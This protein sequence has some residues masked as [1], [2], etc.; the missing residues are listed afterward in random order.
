MVRPR[1][2][3][4]EN[5]K[6]C[7]SSPGKGKIGKDFQ[8]VLTEFVRVVCK[9][10]PD[11]PMSDK[12]KWQQSGVLY[13][14][15]DDGTPFSIAWRLHDAKYFNLAQRRSRMCVLCD[16]GGRED[17][18]ILMDLQC[19]RGSEEDLEPEA[20]AGSGTVV[21]EASEISTLRKGLRWDT[22]P[23]ETERKKV[24]GGVAYRAG[25]TIGF[26]GY[27]S[28]KAGMPCIEEAVPP[29]VKSAPSNVLTA[30]FSYG[31]SASARSIAWEEEMSPTL[32]G[33]EGGNNKPCILSYQET[34]GTLSPGAHPGSYNGQDAYNDL[35]VTGVF[36]ASSFGNYKCGVTSLRAQ[37]GDNGGGSENIV[38][39]KSYVRRLTPDECASLQGF[40]RNWCNIG[41]WVDS[42]GKTHKDADT[43]KYK[44]YGN[45]IAVG[46]ANGQN[47]F[48]CWLARRICAQYE[49]QVTMAS[50]F[51]GIGGFPLAFSACGAIPVW[52]SEIEE[53]PIAVT[54]RRFPE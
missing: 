16:Y 34:T 22:E 6:G 21:G 26:N 8:A 28:A 1:W 48:W 42:K 3:V 11:V 44:A 12:G 38:V 18:A 43:P 35:L 13:G 24:A 52:A 15:G 30:G 49:R 46:Y 7:L 17:G 47:G 10:A 14:V 36:G 20:V 9:D 51:D 19:G 25:T 2:V 39:G 27:Q 33:G 32:R 40:P 41:D 5:V 45:S 23:S 50:L 31:N 54:K 29:L 37:G 4:W 53:F